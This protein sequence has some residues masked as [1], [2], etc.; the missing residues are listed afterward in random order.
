[1]PLKH[2][3]RQFFIDPEKFE[4]ANLIKVAKKK[5]GSE[6]YE[7]AEKIFTKYIQERDVDKSAGYFKFAFIMGTT[8]AQRSEEVRKLWEGMS[9]KYGRDEA[10]DDSIH[11]IL[12]TICMICVAKDPRKWVYVEDEDKRYKLSMDK[13]PDPNQYFIGDYKIPKNMKRKK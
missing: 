2:Y 8:N 11:R 1:M 6:L 10:S 12:G 7:L 9:K 3:K 5:M 4:E 13:V